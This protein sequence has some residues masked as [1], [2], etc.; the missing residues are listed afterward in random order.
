MPAGI[1]GKLDMRDAGKVRL[2]GARQV[3]LHDLHVVDIVLDI[4][5]FGTDAVEDAERLLRVGEEEARNVARV[6]RLDQQPDPGLFQPAGREFQVVDENGLGR[7]RIDPGR[8]DAGKAVDLRAAERP[9]VGYRLVD[10]GAEFLLAPRQDGDA[11][12]AA[13]PVAGGNVEQ[14]LRQPVL[15]QPRGDLLRRM[16]VGA[17][18]FDPLEAGGRGR[19][20]TVEEIML[21][22]Q[23]GKVGGK[24]WHSLH[25]VNRA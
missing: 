24:A 5:V 7:L 21:G 8:H 20:E 4:E 14:H 3:P 13:G 1:V 15:V 25:P 9:G 11:A 12:L 19:V 10:T 2:D 22:E 6:D 17:E 18:I 16:V 23:H